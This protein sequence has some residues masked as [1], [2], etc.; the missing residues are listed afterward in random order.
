MSVF[1]KVW[2]DIVKGEIPGVKIVTQSLHLQVT[3]GE[4]VGQV[5]EKKKG[6]FSKELRGWLLDY[7]SMNVSPLDSSGR[8]LNVEGD[9]AVFV[10]VP[11][12]EISTTFR[13]LEDG[14]PLCGAKV[15]VV[16]MPLYLY[17]RLPRTARYIPLLI[18]QTF[19]QT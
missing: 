10:P 18:I 5:L 19:D 16:L 13:R 4:D 7:R 2:E 9:Y 17:H 3:E 8:W 6:Y 1:E 12:L 11:G 15:R 14:Q